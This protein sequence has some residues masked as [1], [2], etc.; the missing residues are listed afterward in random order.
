MAVARGKKAQA[1]HLALLTSYLPPPR[2]RPGPLKVTR[3]GGGTSL[4]PPTAQDNALTTLVRNKAQIPAPLL[5]IAV[6]NLLPHYTA[7]TPA[8]SELLGDVLDLDF[9]GAQRL[10]QQHPLDALP[11]YP[12]RFVLDSRWTTDVR[13]AGTSSATLEV[14]VPRPFSEMR[15]IVNP[16]HWSGDAFFW[17]SIPNVKVPTVPRQQPGSRQPDPLRRTFRARVN[18]PSNQGS[19]P[20]RVTIYASIDVTPLEVALTFHMRRNA[21]IE[22]CEGSVSARKEEGRPGATRITMHRVLRLRAGQRQQHAILQ[23]WLHSDIVCLA[24]PRRAG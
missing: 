16:T 4:P 20:Q 22:F 3:P 14:C 17:E 8:L 19:K 12:D 15:H 5:G 6:W 9:D 13:S 1:L 7:Q 10:R 23:Y 18:L 24:L 2:R 21:E 11:P